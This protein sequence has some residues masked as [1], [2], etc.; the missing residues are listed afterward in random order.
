MFALLLAI[1]EFYYHEK[2]LIIAS[3]VFLFVGWVLF[4][5]GMIIGA[6]YV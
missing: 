4:F 6:N 3:L 1:L 2:N 5:A